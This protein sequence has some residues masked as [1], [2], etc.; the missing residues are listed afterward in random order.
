MGIKSINQ[1]DWKAYESIAVMRGNLLLYI[2]P[3]IAKSWYPDPNAPKKPGGQQKYTN[4]CIEDLMGI[5]YLL[6][7]NYRALEGF[8]KSLLIISGLSYLSHP[9]RTT[10]NARS[11]SMEIKLPRL[12]NSK[13]GYIV[14]LDSTGLKIHGQGEW[15][16]KK[17]KQRDRANWVKMHI[18]IDNESMQILAVESTADDVQDPEM[19]NH[20]INGLPDTPSAVMGD[21]AYDTFNA[22]A[23]A[24][25]DGFDLIVP[26][27]NTAVVTQSDQ[28]HV[29]ARNKQV[30][31]YQEKGIH[32]WANKNN[33]WERNRVE[34]TMSRFVNTFSDK[35]SA[36][37]VQAQNN[38]IIFKCNIL[39]IM[40]AS[41]QFTQDSAA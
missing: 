17:H 1:R 28:P 30:T 41:N 31:Y 39:N 32:A 2:S 12:S 27:K 18:A 37:T 11:L 26:P 24:I 19:Y 10:I 29:I 38:E 13:A 16:R 21:G 5:K 9:D 8:T 6:G 7:L 34:T 22:Y 35:L 36:R 3:E 23:R 4:K 25:N 15:N 20:L 40:M 14:S 33:Y